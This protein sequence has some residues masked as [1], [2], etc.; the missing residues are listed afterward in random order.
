VNTLVLNIFQS[1]YCNAV[2]AKALH[3]D[4]YDKLQRVLS[5]AD[6]VVSDRGLTS[7]LHDELHCLE[8]Q[9]MVS[10]KLGVMMY[11]CLHGQASRYLADHLITASNVASGLRC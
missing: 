5:A 8:V 10:Y 4:S 1:D 9:E 7:L 2:Y 3:E 6:R 11:R